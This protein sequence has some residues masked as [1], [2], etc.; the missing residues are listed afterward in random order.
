LAADPCK[1]V[2]G[3][4]AWALGKIGVTNYTA[5]CYAFVE[6]AYEL[7]NGIVLDGLGRTAKEAADAYG[8]AGNPGV[9]L[10]GA[11]VFYSCFGTLKGER[12]DWGHVGL[13]LGDGQ[14][15]HA[16]DRVRIDDVYGVEEL[17]P[18]PGFERLKYIGW[19]PVERI[20]RGMTL[21]IRA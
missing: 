6:D 5:L 9:P 11:Y 13:S 10:R 14:V 16:W 2:E 4:I 1:Y 18:A 7:G 17:V 20:L 21:R 15:I 8:A 3:A 19:T 12:R